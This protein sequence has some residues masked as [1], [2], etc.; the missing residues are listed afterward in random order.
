MT[1]P[2]LVVEDDGPVRE[3]LGQTLELAGFSPVLASSFVVAKDM[4]Q[5][6]FQGVILSD[7]RMPGRDGLFLLEHAQ[8]ID[9][10][11]PV[12]LLTGEGDIPTAVGATRKG[13]FDFLEKPCSNEIL[14][15]TVSRAMKAR[16][17]VIEN[18]RLKAM[19]ASGDAAERMIFG[20]SE[21]AEAL[22]AQ[23]RQFAVLD[24]TV[25]IEGAPG[26]GIDKIADV[27]HRLSPRATHPFLR[28]ASAGLS[29][30]QLE[31]HVAECRGGTLY[32]DQ[33]TALPPETQ[34]GLM[35]V[36]DGPQDTR[37]LAGRFST[38]AKDGF[39]TDLHYRLEALTIRVPALKERPEDIPVLFRHYVEQAGEQTGVAPPQITEEVIAGL[40]AQD[41]PG[42]ARALM[43]AATRFVLGQGVDA[44]QN[45][46]G[47]AEK[48]AQVERALLIEG[49]RRH[50]GNAS[51]TAEHFKLPRKTL[52]DKFA[53]YGIK[54]SDFR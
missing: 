20:K 16:T 31:A 53:K 32:L 34:Y 18:R 51:L 12:I 30:D 33:V 19:V 50:D 17:L 15:E 49:L 5:A 14:T 9:A 39:N 6:E 48:L 47:L 8:S 45:D 43:N 21:K 40:M 35:D 41:W 46:M 27:M 11:L 25:L 4:I 37:V 54:P 3:A 29:P 13:A 10:D 1:G 2:V 26:A 7:V 36:L 38:S 42:N 44:D 23:V 52:Y 22:R 28:V 24:E